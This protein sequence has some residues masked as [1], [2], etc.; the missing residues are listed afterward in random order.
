MNPYLEKY[1]KEALCYSSQENNAVICH[2]CSHHC[3]IQIGKR[4]IC[5]VR[6]NMDGKLYSLVYEK[7]IS[8]HIDPIEKKPLYHFYP[9]SKSFSIA[10]IGCN[11]K[12]AWCQNWEIAEC[13]SSRSFIPGNN[14]S[15][16]DIVFE[17]SQSGCRS[18]AYTYTEPTV[19]FEYALETATLAYQKGIVNVFVTN[20]YMT[21][22]AL[23]L[24]QPFLDAANV[25]LKSFR[26]ETYRKMTGAKLQPVLER[27]VEMVEMGI[28]V[29]L[30]TLVIPGV[31]DREEEAKDIAR[32]ISDLDKN[33]P[34]HISRFFPHK[35]LLSTSPTPNNTL[36]MFRAMGEEAGLRYIYLG[37]VREETNTFCPECSKQ[38]IQREGYSINMGKFS[39]TCPDCGYDIAG[40]WD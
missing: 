39:G 3:V 13:P 16:M 4:G 26:D 11:F 29:E 8:S 24:I 21:S 19:F 35:N 32:F 40:R 1:M 9:G 31:N 10:T 7:L 18:I 25:D 38:L 14:Y 20:G 6:E 37:N 22:E 34:W 2:L 15:A 5:G 33:I 27:I 12:C 30:T 23:K 28:W 17:A 36:N